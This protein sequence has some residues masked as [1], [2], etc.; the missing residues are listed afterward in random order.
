MYKRRLK[1]EVHVKWI[2]L[3]KLLIV[4]TRRL[5][6]EGHVKVDITL[7]GLDNV[8]WLICEQLCSKYR[9]FGL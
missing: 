5:R 9:N 1:W 8:K 3:E 7:N 2:L 6:W 4:Y